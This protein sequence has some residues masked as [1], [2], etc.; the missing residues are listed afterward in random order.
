MNTA[1]LMNFM[2]V[3]QRSYIAGYCVDLQTPGEYSVFINIEIKSTD[4]LTR[5]A[6]RPLRNSS[7]SRNAH[8]AFMKPEHDVMRPRCNNGLLNPKKRG[9]PESETTSPRCLC[10]LAHGC[11]KATLSRTKHLMSPSLYIQSLSPR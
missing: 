4:T 2:T 1:S 6:A 9:Q 5:G 10:V 8:H 7:L 3:G 11:L